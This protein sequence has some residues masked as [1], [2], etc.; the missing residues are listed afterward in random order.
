M[1]SC[2]FCEIS[3]S[4][5]FTEHLWET[6]SVILPFFQDNCV[7]TYNP[8]QKDSDGD[9]RGDACDNCPFESNYNQLDSNSD[10][11][12][13][14]CTKDAD[15]D[16]KEYVFFFHLKIWVLRTKTVVSLYHIQ[17]KNL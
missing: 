6:A 15:G 17:F 12:G 2:E 14:A 8:D 10:G 16:G 7:F 11:T 5:F 1:F 13:D 4:T 9:S 3:K